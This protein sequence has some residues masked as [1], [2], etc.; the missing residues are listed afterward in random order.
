MSIFSNI[1]RKSGFR[2]TIRCDESSFLIWKWHPEGTKAGESVCENA[3]RSGSPL[4]VRDGQVAVFVSSQET[5]VQYEYIEGPFDGIIETD[6]LPILAAVLEAVYGG[7]T[8]SPAEVYFINVT[9]IVQMKFAVPFFDLFDSSVPNVGVPVA[10]RGTI[11]FRLEDYGRFVELHSLRT[12]SVE[13]FRKQIRDTVSYC[14]KEILSAAPSVYQTPV[15]QLEKVIAQINES[16]G[17]KLADQLYERFAVT[18]SAVD[19]DAIEF[20][21]TSVGYR[22]REAG[23]KFC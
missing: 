10:V 9:E 3:I 4:W 21:K 20:D 11:N 5:G 14:V 23:A 15:I 22:Q 16:V 12:I 1:F 6:N 8:P 2:D 19:I 18:V 17:Q 7:G 13:E